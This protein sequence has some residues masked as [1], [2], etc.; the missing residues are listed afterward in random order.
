MTA[1]VTRIPIVKAIIFSPAECDVGS[2]VN[3]M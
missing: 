2:V 3:D 1:T